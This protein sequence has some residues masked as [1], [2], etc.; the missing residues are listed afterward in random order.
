MGSLRERSRAAA[1]SLVLVALALQASCFEPVERDGAVACS[2]TGSCPPGFSCHAADQ[3]CYQTPP[4]GD[5]GGEVDGPAADAQVA[6]PD[7][8][9][10]LPACAN[11]IDDDCDGLIDLDDP[12]CADAADTSEHGSKQCD[13]GLDNDSDGG[14][15]FGGGVACGSG[16][17][18]DPQCSSVTDAREDL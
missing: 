11:G 13:D 10:G 6:P 8:D 18:P 5:G 3:R 14:I 1:L 17:T 2:A 7:A 15:D 16:G 4:S 12:G 9:P